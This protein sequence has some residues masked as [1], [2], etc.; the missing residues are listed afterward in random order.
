M[1]KLKTQ[2]ENNL[3]EMT[4]SVSEEEQAENSGF[5]A[6]RAALLPPPALPAPQM[7]VPAEIMVR[8]AATRP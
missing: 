8:E 1:R 4:W 7:P 5:S 2:G 6:S 3:P